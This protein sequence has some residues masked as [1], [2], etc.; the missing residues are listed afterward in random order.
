MTAPTILRKTYRLHQAQL[1]FRQSKALYR[2]FVGGIGSGKSFVG[3]FDLIRRAKPG[4]LYL[5]AAP[6]YPM[7]RDA[8]LRSFLTL[9]RDLFFL[10]DFAKG[11]MIATLGNGAE[12]LFRSTD[13]PERLR[14]PNLSGIWLDEA[15]LMD[16]EVFEVLIGRLREAGEDGF[17]SATFTPKGRHHWSYTVFG[18]HKPNTDL[19]HCH[20]SDNPFLPA[21]F[22]SNV[23]GQYTRHLAAQELEGE[24]IDAPGALFKRDWFTVVEAVPADLRKLRAWDLA[25]TDVKKADD[26]D[27]TA[28]VL[29]GKNADNVYYVLDVRHTQS[30]PRS[31]EALIRQTAEVDGKAVPI[32]MEQEPG[33]SG[34]AVIDN[35]TRRIL[36][37][38]SFKGERS[39]G[40]K[41][42]RAQ[43]FAAQAEAGNV[44][45]LQAPWARA[46]LDEV[47][48]FPLQG[49]G[50][51]D[52]I[53]DAATLAFNKLALGAWRKLAIF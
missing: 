48:A 3:A 36:S 35:Y 38:W 46:F 41:A 51:H 8:T 47:E 32:W 43:P 30:S 50:I 9:A 17:L 23:R 12:V 27:W 5:V 45:V 16:Q 28:G 49:K 39:T 53:V 7:L 25:A 26:P 40:D 34:V 52:D 2:G 44:R 21:H 11:E 42:T 37:G 20:T 24:F 6:T 10:K 13:D 31:V 1:R 15:S 22:Y 18:E 29:L 19:V 4:R 33:A 14:G